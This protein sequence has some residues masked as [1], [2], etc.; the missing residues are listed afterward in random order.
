MRA[1]L[2]LVLLATA[3]G[4]PAPPPGPTR[5]TGEWPVEVELAAGATPR[6]E[7][8]VLVTIDTL[9]ADHVSAHGYRRKTTPFLDS[10]AERGVLFERAQAT[11][12]HTAPSH[13]SM[14]TGLPPLVH[15]VLHNGYR[16]EE[17]A[18]DL[19][20]VFAAAGFETAACVNTEFLQGV[21]AQFGALS[22]TIE[23]GDT[24]LASARRWLAEER[25]T[26]RFFLWVHLF[27]PHHWKGFALEV[28][29]ERLFR[30]KAP[31]D[32]TEY[33]LALHGLTPETLIGQR[34]E[35]EVDRPVEITSLEQYLRF[36]DGYDALIQYADRQLQGL[37]E[38][39]EGLGLAGPT[40]WIV[41]SDHG[42][43]L[44][45]HGLHG[46]GGHI[47]QEQL[48]VPLVVHAS[49]GSLG[50]RRVTAL[51]TH[52]DLFPTLLEVVGGRARAPEGLLE[53]RSL[54]PL[55]SGA[56]SDW[57]G[58]TLFAQRKPTEEALYALR[59]A[60]HKLLDSATK[61]DELYDLEQDPLEL[62]ER[63]AEL[64]ETR[65][66]LAAELERR[67]ALYAASAQGSEDQEIPEAWLEELRDLGYVR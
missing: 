27:D 43:G 65:A 31:P 47:Y 61:P 39:V 29:S 48:A 57:P 46:H 42:E 53:G 11:V 7:R 8:V 12:S 62:A 40:L 63:S 15:G 55:I 51:T 20:R 66:A 10:L 59:D 33:V 60:R 37:Y 25:Q 24:V 45:S 56:E 38:A 16:I 2:L 50:P 21:A 28:E 58:R 49:D 4:D 26:P 19:A 41:T 3:C 34:W 44:A 35:T 18:V 64:A 1:P 36:V 5:V 14:L 9:R 17:G 13:T 22:W 32:W 30:G 23:R 6:F 52:L 54:W 67:L